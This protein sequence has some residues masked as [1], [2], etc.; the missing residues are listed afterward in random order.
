MFFKNFN[1]NDRYLVYITLI[2]VS[3]CFW[4]IFRSSFVGSDGIRYY[5][6]FDDGLISFKYALNLIKGHGL[7]WNPNEFIEGFSNPLW[8]IIMACSIY[9]FGQSLAPLIIQ[10]LGFLFLLLSGITLYKIIHIINIKFNIIENNLILIPTI[11]F[12]SYYPI[13]YWALSGMEVSFLIYLNITIFHISFK[14]LYLEK[15]KYIYLIVFIFISIAYLTRPDGFLTIL[16]LLCLIIFHDYKNKK[17]QLL[18]ILASS[19]IFIFS[20]IFILY[21]RYFIYQDIAPNTYHLKID[22][23]DLI[24]RLRNGI[25]FVKLFIIEIS[26]FLFLSIYIV[27]KNI[28]NINMLFIL[29]I[30]L[31]GLFYQIYVGGDP[32]DRWRQLVPS[33]FIYFI[34][35]YLVLI[36]IKENL[37]NKKT[38]IILLLII[39]AFNIIII[40]SGIQGRENDVLAYQKIYLIFLVLFFV[41]I[42]YLK[43]NHIIYLLI[44]FSILFSDYRYFEEQLIRR[45][46]LYSFASQKPQVDFAIKLNKISNENIKLGLFWAGTI[47]YYTHGYTIDFLGKCDNYISTLKPDESISWNGMKGVPGHSKYNLNYSIKT[48]EPDWIENYKWGKDNLI[49]YVSKNYVKLE[50]DNNILDGCFKNN[51]K[52]IYWEKVNIIGNCQ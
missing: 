46:L 43:H 3:W 25:G 15:N 2:Y 51:S 34:L 37:I 42:K 29:L 16:P 36:N 7:V 20:I 32:W 49:D 41:L 14:H 33:L 23:Y 47:P 38:I 19:A 17:L 31:I 39:A 11:L 22:G 10:L 35:F 45:S 50:Y 18:N 8:T 30:P 21:F 5:L 12:W 28:K 26:I 27:M 1:R 52:N 13:S 4:F 9:V 44:I 48:L 40:S 6:I 24:L